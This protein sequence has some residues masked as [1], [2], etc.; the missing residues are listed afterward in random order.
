MRFAI[1]RYAVFWRSYSSMSD[2]KGNFRVSS[3][4]AESTPG[5]RGCP[6]TRTGPF[7]HQQHLGKVMWELLLPTKPAPEMI[8][9]IHC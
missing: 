5:E 1:I 2:Q 7:I 6:R 9:S 8:T 3:S 4:N